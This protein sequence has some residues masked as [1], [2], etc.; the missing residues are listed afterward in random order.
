[1]GEIAARWIADGTAER[2]LLA[3]RA[4][5]VRR[6]AKVAAILG[7][8]RLQAQNGSLHAWLTL[9]EPWQ[10]E[11]FA[12]E[13]AARGV[14]VVPSGS[15]HPG[16]QPPLEAVRICFGAPPRDAEVVRGVEILA[17]LLAEAPLPAAALL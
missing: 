16:P 10:A 3:K 14:S 1:M 8:E 6:L 17:R 7:P 15:F 4:A 13:A 2:S 5:A 12:A 9:P 11:A